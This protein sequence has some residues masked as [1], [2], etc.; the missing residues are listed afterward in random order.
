VFI[1]QLNDARR[2]YLFIFMKPTLSIFFLFSFS[3]VIIVVLFLFLG[4]SGETTRV[5]R[6][7]TGAARGGD[8]K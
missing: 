5:P 8:E 1:A 7:H 2:I 4:D 3:V 6:H